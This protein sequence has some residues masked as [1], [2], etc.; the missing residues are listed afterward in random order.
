MYLKVA[1]AGKISW[2]KFMAGLVGCPEWKP[3]APEKARKFGK[4]LLR[5]LQ[6]FHYYSQFFKK[7]KKPKYKFLAFGR[8]A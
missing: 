4:D 2:I 7:I 3:R 8:K 5:K 1:Y 6:K